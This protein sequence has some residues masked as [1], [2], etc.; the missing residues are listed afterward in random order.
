MCSVQRWVRLVLF[1]FAFFVRVLLRSPG[2]VSSLSETTYL[3]R[4]VSTIYVASAQ[5]T[6]AW[7][8]ACLEESPGCA[9]SMYRQGS[10]VALSLT[11]LYRICT[12]VSISHLL[13][14]R[15]SRHV[16]VFVRRVRYS[17][18]LGRRYVLLLGFRV[19]RY[20]PGTK[21]VGGLSEAGSRKCVVARQEFEG[22][23]RCTRSASGSASG[24]TRARLC[25]CLGG[26]DRANRLAN[27]STSALAGEN[28]NCAPPFVCFCVCS[29]KVA[30]HAVRWGRSQD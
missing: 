14:W 7:K 6:S 1:L 22:T 4:F 17:Q 3:G 24:S 27:R 18:E 15:N 11:A 2:L 26:T 8:S 30:R 16:L 5:K 9:A 12:D 23:M 28:R 10:T 29:C 19:F 25:F 21:K 20:S 13:L